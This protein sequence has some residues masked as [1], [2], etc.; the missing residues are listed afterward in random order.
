MSTLDK[1]SNIKFCRKLKEGD[2]DIDYDHFSII[3]NG[4]QVILQFSVKTVSFTFT[5]KFID[6]IG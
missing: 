6:M 5:D 4:K 3:S 1:I 2:F